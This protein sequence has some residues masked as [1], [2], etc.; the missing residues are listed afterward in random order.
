MLSNSR[1][2]E[3]ELPHL[4]NLLQ[5]LWFVD[6]SPHQSL[7]Q[8]IVLEE[9]RKGHIFQGKDVHVALDVPHNQTSSVLRKLHHD[10]PAFGWIF[11]D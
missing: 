7:R 2:V 5:Q 3:T 9:R 11:R 8:Q 10:I 1:L 6:H 4:L